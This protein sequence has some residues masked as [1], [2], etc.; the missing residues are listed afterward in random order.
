MSILLGYERSKQLVIPLSLAFLVTLAYAF[1]EAGLHWFLLILIPTY[2]LLNEAF[3]VQMHES[4]SCAAFAAR[5]IYLK[6]FIF[7]TALVDFACI[8]L[9]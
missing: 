6:A 2:V 4:A 5:T 9:L 8:Q 7:V 3:R 1:R